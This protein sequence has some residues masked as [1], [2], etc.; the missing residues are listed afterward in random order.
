VSQAQAVPFGCVGG[1][2]TARGDQLK[3]TSRPEQIIEKF[4]R[5]VF[6]FRAWAVDMYRIATPERHLSPIPYAKA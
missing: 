3:F 5:A 6:N 4:L 2:R 1:Q